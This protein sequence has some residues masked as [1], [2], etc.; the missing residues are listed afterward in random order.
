MEAGPCHH[1]HLEEIHPH[2]MQFMTDRMRATEAFNVGDECVECHA[3]HDAILWCNRHSC[4]V[5]GAV[6]LGAVYCPQDMLLTALSSGIRGPSPLSSPPHRLVWGAGRTPS[7]PS[8]QT[9]AARPCHVRHH[10]RGMP[11]QQRRNS[12]VACREVVLRHLNPW[13]ATPPPQRTCH[14]WNISRRRR[15]SPSSWPAPRHCRVITWMVDRG[16]A[17]RISAPTMHRLSPSN[18]PGALA[19]EDHSCAHR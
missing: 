1:P 15:R 11:Q 17:R 19:D 7:P 4:T 13:N 12:A 14:R 18:T 6:S 5:N 2:F 16:M 10:H 9:A 3:W 8:Q